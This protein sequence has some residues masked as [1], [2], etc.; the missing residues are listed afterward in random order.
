M[1]RSPWWQRVWTLQEQV[2]ARQCEAYHGRQSISISSLRPDPLGIFLEKYENGN[3]SYNYDT[4]HHIRASCQQYNAIQQ[5]WPNSHLLDLNFVAQMSLEVAFLLEAKRP[6]DKIYGL[7][8]I[9]TAYCNL[10]LS[11]PDYE[12]TAEDVYEETVW[13]W[14]K[15][16]G[17]LSILKLAARPCLV[18]RLPSWVPAWHQQ[19]PSLVRNIGLSY[20]E[21]LRIKGNGH[22]K[23]NCALD[24]DISLISETSLDLPGETEDH[25]SVATILS[26]GNL[27]VSHARFA[28]RVSHAIGPDRSHE[29][30]W[31]CS[32]IQSLYVHLDWCK[33]IHDVF[34][35]GSAAHEAA[36][37]ELYRSLQGIHQFEL[38]DGLIVK[39][40]ESFRAWFDFML[41]LNGASGFPTLISGRTDTETSQGSGVELYFDICTADQEEDAADVLECG[42]GGDAQGREGL[43]KLAQH[44]RSTQR[45]LVFVRN[46]SLCILDKDNMIAVTDYWC[47]E[48]DEVF[49]FP[50]TD[51]PFV[52]RKQP[53]GDCY[54]LVGPALVDRLWRVGYQDWR[55]EGDDLQ[56][57]VLI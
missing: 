19:H 5:G 45:G 28:G 55:S 22:F 23:W 50:G 39:K 33:L 9:L 15:T 13:A 3:E 31:Y 35:H 6:V 18:Q 49:V 17:D 11:P 34:L 1:R 8:S 44:I 29:A 57:I 47:Q 38:S 43:I 25:V 56:D 51:S 40:F 16:R 36:L 20:P 21:R 46:H 4:R 41:Y 12:K 2:F 7:Y 27:R 53:D 54:R 14:I 52:L 24:R 10:P 30:D 32:S 48:G 42:Y 37:N 26:H